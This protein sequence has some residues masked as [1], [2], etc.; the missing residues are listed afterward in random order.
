MSCTYFCIHHVAGAVS[1][2]PFVQELWLLSLYHWKVSIVVGV[3]LIAALIIMVSLDMFDSRM[4]YFLALHEAVM[5]AER[6]ARETGQATSDN[7]ERIF[8]TPG[9]FDYSKAY[10]LNG[11]DETDNE[12]YSKAYKLNRG[13]DE[14]DKKD[15]S[16]A[17][18]LNGTYEIDDDE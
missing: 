15:Y 7:V 9:G 1:Q 2:D 18:E 10:K 8:P 11:A 4:A 5:Q 3:V 14:T 16:W 17:Y 13:A 12:N 6:L